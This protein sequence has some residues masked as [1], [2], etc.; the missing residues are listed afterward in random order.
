[1]A[2]K[3]FKSADY[4]SKLAVRGRDR[5]ADLPLFRITDHRAGP[6]MDV[7][8]A[9]QRPAVHADGRRCTWMYETRSETMSRSDWPFSMLPGEVPGERRDGSPGRS[10][11]LTTRSRH[12]YVLSL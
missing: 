5:T 1:M 3:S 4:K 7:S 10:S 8:L 12:R 2:P 6:A 9:G 11:C